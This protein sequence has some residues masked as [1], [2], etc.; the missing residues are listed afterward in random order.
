MKTLITAA[1]LTVAATSSMAQSHKENL[2]TKNVNG[3]HI[4]C[5][6]HMMDDLK[7]CHL[8]SG[9]DESSIQL[10]KSVYRDNDYC[11]AVAGHNYPGRTIGQVRVGNESVYIFSGG[12]L[13][14]MPIS[15]QK[16]LN[17][18]NIFSAGDTIKVEY[19]IWPY[20]KRFAKYS[21]SGIEEAIQELETMAK[22]YKNK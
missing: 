10:L 15:C 14:G 2:Q 4:E 22:A 5:Y 6:T 20:G 13:G 12:P 9:N 1:A 7:W 11:I 17:N 19:D 16:G 8:S 3:F 18:T 21:I